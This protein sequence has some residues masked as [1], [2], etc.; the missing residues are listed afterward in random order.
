[1]S[2]L[3]ELQVRKA[4]PTEK[5]YK[6]FDERGLY[7]EVRPNGGKWWRLRY[8]SAGKERLLSLGTYPDVGLKDARSRRDDARR[9]LADGIDPSEHRKREKREAMRRA[10][11]SFEVVAREFVTK[12]SN[13]WTAHHAADVLHRLELY[14]FP[15]LGARPIAEIDAPELL[16]CLRK[17]EGRGAFELAGRMR[18]VAGQIFRYGIATGACSRDVAADL[19]GAL[20]PPRRKNFPHIKPEE[21]PELLAAID[22]CDRPPHNCDLQTRLGLEFSALTFPRPKEIRGATWDEIDFDG[23]I[24]VI[25]AERMKMKRDHLVPLSRQAL[26]VL[27]RLWKLNGDTPYLLIGRNNHTSMSENTLLYALYRIGFHGRMCGHGFRHVASTVLNEHE[28]EN[29]WTPDAIE[30]QLSHCEGSD[31]RG[32]YNKAQYLTQRREMMQWWA[33]HLDRLRAPAMAAE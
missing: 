29:V 10:A 3:S 33:D 25:G 20:T 11:H 14:L 30:R 2:K 24:W 1:M 32:T 15:D 6:L 21:L 12:Q 9:L 5:P 17:T 8:R 27:R 22:A 31:V 23:A 28:E 7:V 26:A 16:A 19:K 4:K 13:R 18:Q